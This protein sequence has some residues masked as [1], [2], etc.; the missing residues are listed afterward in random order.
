[1]N[2][3]GVLSAD[4]LLAFPDY[5][6]NERVFQLL[7]QVSGRAG[8]KDDKGR[9]LIQTHRA[10][11]PIIKLVEEHNY[12]QFY[13]LEE[14]HR[15]DFVYP[16]YCKLIRITIKHKDKS[17]TAQAALNLIV[18]LSKMENIHLIGPAEPP[19][20]RIRNQYL[21]EILIKLPNS[22][23][24]ISTVKNNI[25][26]AVNVLTSKKNFSSVRVVLDV[27]P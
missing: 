19:V 23:K 14:N 9:V 1:M 10:D 3:V 15:K 2:L 7:E 20:S 26:D 27:D 18:E 11:H 17:H 6:V 22:A 24:A 16:P 4:S 8:R 5:R 21:Q 13:Q 12:E 25:Y